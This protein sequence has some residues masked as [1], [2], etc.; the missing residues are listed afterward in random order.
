MKSFLIMLVLSAMALLTVP[1][2]AY[3]ATEEYDH[4][5]AH[6]GALSATTEIVLL[7]AGKKLKVESID[8]VDADAISASGVNYIT[9]QLRLDG[10]SIATATDTQAGLSARAPLS[11]PLHDGSGA[12]LVISKDSVLSLDATVSGTGALGKGS[13]QMQYKLIGN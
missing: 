11:I 8:V 10:T 6:L 5:S 13:V 4:A 7:K 2:I 3:S 1:Q 9:Y 12:D